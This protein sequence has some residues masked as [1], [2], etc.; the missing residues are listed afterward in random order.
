VLGTAGAG[1]SGAITFGTSIID[2]ALVF[3]AS[4]TPFT[5]DLYTDPNAIADFGDN[6]SI[7]FKGLTWNSGGAG[8]SATL[9]GSTLAVTDGTDT[10]DI[11]LSGTQASQYYTHND[12]HGGVVVTD[13]P[14]CF[15]RGTLILTERG[16]VAVENLR[17]GD[18]VVT[19]SGKGA[20]L[21]PIIWIG[22]SRFDAARHPKPQQVWPVRILQ[23]AFGPGMPRRD[24]LVSPRHALF[25]DGGL[26]PAE[27][28]VN[29][30]TIFQ[31]RSVTRGEYFHVELEQHDIVLAEGLHAE[32]Y[33]EWGDN[34]SMF[35]NAAAH[36]ALHPG[37]PEHPAGFHGDL[38]FP[39][40][41]RGAALEALRARLLARAGEAGCTLVEDRSIQLVTNDG[42]VILPDTVEGKRIRFLIPEGAALRL[43]SGRWTPT[44]LR[45]A[46]KDIRTLG[47]CVRRIVLDDARDLPLESIASWDGWHGLERNEK[48]GQWRW[49]NGSARLPAASG[50]IT[51]E[52]A[53]GTYHWTA[54]EAEDVAETRRVA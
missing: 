10:V 24:L 33:L 42:Q 53:A 1:G 41:E 50:S 30:A 25:A 9:T 26:I 49:T 12:G 36:R 23:G 3:D 15:L 44:E 22:H 11:T 13:S 16:Q 38:C 46:S 21:K 40:V 34:R 19:F 48:G 2:P 18:R 8:D 14:A 39:L 54:P 20:P 43:V 35:E 45:V 29:G 47:V 51:I 32:T 17:V 37:F 31:N 6:D 27:R 52:L 7:D 28:L 5:S 4:A